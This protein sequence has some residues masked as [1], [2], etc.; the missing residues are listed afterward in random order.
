[1][2]LQ[3]SFDEVLEDQVLQRNQNL[4]Y[5]FFHLRETE[6]FLCNFFFFFCNKRFGVL[7]PKSTK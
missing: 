4:Y 7:D 2:Q 6:P 1:M 3:A 5:R